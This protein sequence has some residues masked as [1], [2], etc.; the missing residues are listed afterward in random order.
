MPTNRTGYTSDDGTF[1]MRAVAVMLRNGCVLL[2]RLE[3]EDLWVLPGGRVFIG[4][5]AQ[6]AVKREI[7]DEAGF[8]I[9]V[10]RLLWVIENF[11]TYKGIEESLDIRHDARVHDI[12][13][14]FLVTPEES[15]GQWQ[16]EEFQG[17]DFPERPDVKIIFKWFVREELEDLNLVPPILK[18]L[19]KEIPDRTK[20]LVN[21]SI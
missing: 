16:E 7:K 10:E 5:T 20:H 17:A 18:D 12:G 6:D 15:A 4:E 14:Y 11:F 8:E 2:S 1:G 21:R 3:Y 9:G 13:F 19:L